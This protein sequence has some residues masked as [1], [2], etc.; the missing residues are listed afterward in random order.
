M[1]KEKT[2]KKRGDIK[3]TAPTLKQGLDTK[4]LIYLFYYVLTIFFA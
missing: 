4:L 1:Y 2:V 3:N